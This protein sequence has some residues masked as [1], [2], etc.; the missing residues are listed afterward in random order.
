MLEEAA[1]ENILK[2]CVLDLF[3]KLSTAGV[4]APGLVWPG[5]CLQGVFFWRISESGSELALQW[6]AS[7]ML[8][9]LHRFVVP[10]ESGVS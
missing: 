6:V 4:R 7:S 9:I 5:G 8:D 10:T 2:G 3:L 1:K